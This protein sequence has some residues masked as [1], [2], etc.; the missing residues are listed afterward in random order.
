MFTGGSSRARKPQS[1]QSPPSNH[2][3]DV[4]SGKRLHNHGKSPF[5][6]GKYTISMVIFHSYVS[7]PEGRPFRASKL[8]VGFCR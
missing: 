8:C 7:L 4:P 2:Q 1:P 5:F 3:G 6:M